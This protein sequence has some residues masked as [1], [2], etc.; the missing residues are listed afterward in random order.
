MDE[1]KNKEVETARQRT[2]QPPSYARAQKMK[3]PTLH[4]H[5]CL[6]DSLTSFNDDL[7]S[8]TSQYMSVI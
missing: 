8:D 3:L 2:G 4:D 5:V 7:H 6:R 1:Q